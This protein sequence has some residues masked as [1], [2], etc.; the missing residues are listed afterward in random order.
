M[1][2]L[3]D[4]WSGVKSI[5]GPLLGFGG[6]VVRSVSDQSLTASSN[7]TNIALA[8]EANAINQK[9]AEADRALQREFAQYGVRWKVEDAK[10][11]GLHPLAA[12]GASTSSPSPSYVG[13]SFPTTTPAPSTDYGLSAF[14]QSLDRAISS[15]MTWAER[16]EYAE[17]KLYESQKRRQD[18]QI[19]ELELARL[20]RDLQS[21]PAGASASMTGIIPGQTGINSIPADQVM[22]SRLGVE[23]AV[24][25]FHKMTVD[26]K[27]RIY[28]V[29]GKSA[30]EALENDL[31]SKVLYDTNAIF[32][33]LSNHF[34][35]AADLL[36][37][38]SKYR[39]SQTEKRSFF[40]RELGIPSQYVHY[41]DLFDQ[42]YV[43]KAGRKLLNK[44]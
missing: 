12:L 5:A 27:G 34:R 21:L 32:D 3:G 24:T 20:E 7:A 19:G 22:S 30:E 17:K 28:M 40:A 14:G 8:R 26:S 10:A 15:K 18:L 25:P 31:P 43:D 42:W 36:F 23:K 39:A 9:N 37:P 1:S 33:T 6:D 11:A 4:L 35:S 44:E 13:A 38:S 16:Q 41:N 2:F 29:I